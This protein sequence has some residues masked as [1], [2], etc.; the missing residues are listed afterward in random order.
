MTQTGMYYP[1][2]TDG[3]FALRFNGSQDAAQEI[4]SALDTPVHHVL[5]GTGHV[6]YRDGELVIPD[7]DGPVLMG[8]WVVVS[9]DR[10][11]RAVLDDSDFRELYSD[12]GR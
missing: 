7:C 8:Q 5:P 2:R 11:L 9:Q 1:R 6:G 4:A 12:D 3:V 10:K